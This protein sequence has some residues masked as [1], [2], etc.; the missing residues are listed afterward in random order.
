MFMVERKHM[1]HVKLDNKIAVYGTDNPLVMSSVVKTGKNMLMLNAKQCCCNYIFVI[2]MFEPL[3]IEQVAATISSKRIPEEESL[4]LVKENQDV[5]LI[6]PFT[7][8]RMVIPVRVATENDIRCFDLLGFLMH[9][10]YA[11]NLLSPYTNE[12]IELHSL[13]IDSLLEKILTSSDPSLTSVVIHSDG[14][15][16]AS[17]PKEISTPNFNQAK[18]FR[19]DLSVETGM[20]SEIGSIEPPTAHVVNSIMTPGTE[21]ILQAQQDMFDQE[22]KDP[23]LGYL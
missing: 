9:N 22:Q 4:K 12:K 19:M 15:F 11:L 5:P 21:V 18:K 16:D 20:S 17:N 13:V 2:Q 7:N 14:T 23:A 10:R 8:V 6:C 3:S 1:V